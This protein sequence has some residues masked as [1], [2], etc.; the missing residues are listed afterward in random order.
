MEAENILT[1]AFKNIVF[2]GSSIMIAFKIQ[3]F[4]EIRL[5]GEIS[6]VQNTIGNHHKK[7]R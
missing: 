2:F 5:E 7:I 1:V 4:D 3:I 6:C